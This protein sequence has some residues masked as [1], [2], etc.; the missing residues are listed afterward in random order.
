MFS[1]IRRRSRLYRAQIYVGKLSE[2]STI[3]IE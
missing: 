2:R 1:F 3:Y